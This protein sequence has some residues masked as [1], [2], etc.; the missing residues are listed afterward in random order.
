M[1]LIKK[2]DMVVKA[3]SSVMVKKLLRS[4]QWHQKHIPSINNICNRLSSVLVR[5]RSN[6]YDKNDSRALGPGD[7]LRTRDAYTNWHSS[8]TGRVVV[9]S[10]S[11]IAGA[12]SMKCG[13]ESGSCKSTFWHLRQMSTK[14]NTPS[15]L[16]AETTDKITSTV[17]Q[18]LIKSRRTT[19]AFVP[20]KLSS[21]SVEDLEGAI[22]RAVET[23]VTAPNHHRTESTS[24][25]RI[26]WSAE[27]EK[28]SAS[29]SASS[30]SSQGKTAHSRLMDI[31]YNVT[32]LRNLN[33]KK[34]FK[35]SN[36]NAEN[37]RNKWRD[38]LGGYIVVCMGKQP[39]QDHTDNTNDDD[40]DDDELPLQAS[41]LEFLKPN[42]DDDNN[43]SSFEVDQKS[44]SYARFQ[45]WYSTM[46]LH[47][48]E[49]ER[50]LEDYAS[51]SASIQN[52]LLSLHSE[53]IPVSEVEVEVEDINKETDT[54]SDSADMTRSSGNTNMH[55]CNIGSKWAT[56]PMISC[57]AMRHL[58]GCQEDD[59]IVGLIMVGE[60]KMVPTKDWRRRRTFEGNVFRCL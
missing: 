39:I 10:Y 24:Y 42:D 28:L 57:R 44:D 37:K 5:H 6:C 35:D 27:S 17:F 23:A 16:A 8:N 49:T 13:Q 15:S 7:S 31:C 52:I 32:L 43:S 20:V 26:M 19:P 25:Y 9:P 40:E 50:Q 53:N 21:L 12:M 46:P 55:T 14:A 36:I 60:P 4:H 3:G 18:D 29:S 34:N 48:P 30:I 2:Y 58:I 54:G 56:G 59:A 51:A 22:E 38:T 11:R 47:P 33:K 1:L 41:E 45:H